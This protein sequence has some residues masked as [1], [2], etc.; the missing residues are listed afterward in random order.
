MPGIRAN[1]IAKRCCLGKRVGSILQVFGTRLK[2]YHGSWRKFLSAAT[3][4]WATSLA[5]I[6]TEIKITFPLGWLPTFPLLGNPTT[7][8]RLWGSIS[9]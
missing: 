4:Y 6:F 5:I 2:R 9:R 1:G 7:I 3:G 8:E